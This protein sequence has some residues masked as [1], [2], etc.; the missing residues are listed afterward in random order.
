MEIICLQESLANLERQI[1]AFE[2]SYLED[3]LA[4]GN[5]IRGWE[6]YLTAAKSVTKLLEYLLYTCIHRPGNSS[7]RVD[8]KRKKFSD[9]E[10]LFSRSSVTSHAVCYHGNVLCHPLHLHGQH[11][12]I[13]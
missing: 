4:Y 12:T 5:V 10:R 6:G 8:R 2:G 1:Y 11:K 13:V 7:G 9:S 3:T